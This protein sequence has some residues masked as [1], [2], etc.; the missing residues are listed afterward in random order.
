MER[1]K[2]CGSCTESKDTSLQASVISSEF[3]YVFLLS[4]IQHK[5]SACDLCVRPTQVAQYGACPGQILVVN[6]KK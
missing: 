5:R 1:N 3:Y 6:P 4:Q 2:S